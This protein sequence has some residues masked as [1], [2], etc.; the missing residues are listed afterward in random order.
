MMARLLLSNL[1]RAAA[2]GLPSPPSF[3]VGAT[4]RSRFKTERH[5]GRESMAKHP[6]GKDAPFGRQCFSPFTRLPKPSLFRKGLRARC[7]NRSPLT[8]SAPSPPSSRVLPTLGEGNRPQPVQRGVQG[9][10]I[11]SLHMGQ[12]PD[13]NSPP[14]LFRG[15]WNRH[16]RGGAQK[17]LTLDFDKGV[18][19]LFSF[20]SRWGG[21]LFAPPPPSFAGRATYSP[22]APLRACGVT[23][24]VPKGEE[25]AGLGSDDQCLKNGP[26]PRTCPLPLRHCT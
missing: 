7:G 15:F 12:H 20:L 17:T 24:G 23:R 1:S 6:R 11:S 5:L 26:F 3:F 25:N 18:F 22:P 8:F 2:P 10:R 4:S 13:Q 21:E 19:L 9:L 14:M 16:D